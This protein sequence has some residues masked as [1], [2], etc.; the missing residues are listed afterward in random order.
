MSDELAHHDLAIDQIF[1]TA[2]TYKADFQVGFLRENAAE[3]PAVLKLQDNTR[4]KE[5]RWLGEV[6]TG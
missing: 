1:R 6:I 3:E 5:F 4:G 2:E